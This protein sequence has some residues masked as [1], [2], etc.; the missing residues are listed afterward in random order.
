[1]EYLDLIDFHMSWK[2]LSRLFLLLEIF[3]TGAFVSL[4]LFISLYIIFII[5][6][7]SGNLEHWKKNCLIVMINCFVVKINGIKETKSWIQLIKYIVWNRHMLNDNSLSKKIVFKLILFLWSKIIWNCI[8]IN[9]II[10]LIWL[11]F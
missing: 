9:I 2:L 6:Y 1:M 5:N 4:L 11:K 10:D 3:I 8:V 7:Q